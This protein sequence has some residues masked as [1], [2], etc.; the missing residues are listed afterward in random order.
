MHEGHRQRMYDKLKN[1]DGLFDHELL[2]ILL[3]NALPRK[4]TNPIAHELLDTFGSLAGVLA[5]DTE[6]LKAVNGVGENVALYL[7][8][9]GECTR[10]INV[11]SAGITVLK[12]HETIKQFT[13]ARMR[14]KT[15]E[16]MEIYCLDKNSRVKRICS[17]SN[18]E[19]NKVAVDSDKIMNVLNAEKPSGV[20][21]AHNHLSGNKEPSVSDDKFT[22]GFQ[23]LCSINNARLL[24]HLIYA[25][26]K[27]VY[28]YFAAGELDSI[29]ADF[30]F[31]SVIAEKM[32]KV[33]KDKKSD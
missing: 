6:K 26:D 3:F 19:L 23:L 16:V 27:E 25:S 32:N 15:V 17:F 28:S 1:D 29:S 10:R 8:C 7:K 12:N 33:F 14:G 21:V 5:A 2:E 4:N 9:I 24:D 20:I 22:A 13:V 31:K 18:D 30:S 11:H